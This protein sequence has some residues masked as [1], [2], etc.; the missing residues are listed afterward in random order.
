MWAV[1]LRVEM[2]VSEMEEYS[3]KQCPGLNSYTQGCE[4]CLG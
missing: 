1:D 2:K 4:M 3:E